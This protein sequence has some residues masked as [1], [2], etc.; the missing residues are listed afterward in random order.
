MNKLTIPENTIYSRYLNSIKT[1]SNC[2]EY[3]KS[4]KTKKN[5]YLSIVVR[6]QGKRLKLLYDNLLSLSKQKNNDFEIVLVEHDV[7][8]TKEDNINQV[9]KQFDEEFRKKIECIKV[10]K[11][12]RA[13]PLNYGFLCANGKYIVCLD[14][15]DIA[16]NNFTDE[17]I[18]NAKKHYGQIIHC[19]S[20]FQVWKINNDGECFAE[21]N[22]NKIYCRNFNFYS[23][24]KNNFCPINSVA[25]PAFY[26]KELGIVFDEKLEVFEDYEY[27]MRVA[28]ISGVYNVE[29][30]TSLYRNFINIDNSVNSVNK[31]IWD[32]NKR[33]IEMKLNKTITIY[34]DLNIGDP[35]LDSN[36]YAGY[37]LKNEILEKEKQEILN[38]TSWKITKPLRSIGRIVGKIDHKK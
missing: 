25:Y 13:K 27:L 33:I 12:K 20:D 35:N 38:S 31:D 21:T 34:N 19:Y 32:K 16:Y 2:N 10:F 5:V 6:T 7:D 3:K 9:V 1:I 28:S 37:K 36:D 8:Q 4:K 30:S 22:I 17:I 11:G 23:Q 14:D 18:K 26:F 29:K 24:M 15:D